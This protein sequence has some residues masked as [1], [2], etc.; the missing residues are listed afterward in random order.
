MKVCLLLVGYK[1]AEFLK[2]FIYP[3]EAVVS[4]RDTKDTFGKQYYNSI[5]EICQQRNILFL[6][7]KDQTDALFEATDKIVAI[8]WQFLLKTNLE[9]VIVFHDS[10]LPKLRGFCPTTTA[11]IEG[12]QALGV[13]AFQPTDEIDQ[14][15]I[16]TIRQQHIN[17][18]IN[19]KQAFD[20][21]CN[22]YV[23]CITDIIE[24]QTKPTMKVDFEES[25][26]S[27]WRDADD[28]LVDWTWSAGKIKR[29][30]DALQ[31][32]NAGARTSY[33]DNTIIIK[34]AQVLPEMQFVI[35]DVAKIWSI[36]NNQPVVICGQGML[37]IVE[38]AHTDDA[39]VQFT[40]LRQRLG[41]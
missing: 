1:G 38:A 19:A 10:A 23:E 36:K 27:I 2:K 21:I 28:Y 31:F 17:Y 15:P 32:P 13:T 3:V 6:N 25:T 29:F 40:K 33:L 24:K 35:R 30:I 26:F 41:K 7:K 20:I 5:K 16:Y 18:P 39:P 22:L 34:E 9:K 37:Q 11:L 14:G 8:G 4:Y 12:L